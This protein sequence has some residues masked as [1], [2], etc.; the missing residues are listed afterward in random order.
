MSGSPGDLKKSIGKLVLSANSDI[1]ELQKSNKKS[2][3]GDGNVPKSVSER[4]EKLAEKKAGLEDGIKSLSQR[5]DYIKKEKFERYI[6]MM[7]TTV[8]SAK[9]VLA[10]EA[11]KNVTEEKLDE[12]NKE[13]KACIEE[14]ELSE[15][16]IKKAVQSLS[17]TFSSL[18][19]PAV[20]VENDESEDDLDRE[21]GNLDKY[22]RERFFKLKKEISQKMME[23]IKKLKTTWQEEKDII[24]YQG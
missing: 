19:G 2:N 23:Q 12:V 16:E 1:L 11:D 4:E 13:A 17:E 15:E 6:K 18:S 9:I 14:V 21:V 20:D 5:P 24:D 7:E 10:K 3:D 22:L 8:E